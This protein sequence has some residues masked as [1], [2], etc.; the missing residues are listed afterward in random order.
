MSFQLMHIVLL[1]SAAHAGPWRSYEVYEPEISQHFVV[2]ASTHKLTYNH[3]STI[4]WFG[5]RWFCLWNANTIASEGKPGQLNYVSTSTDGITWSEPRAAFA[6]PEL[7]E[8][9]VPCPDGTQWQPNLIVVDGKLWAIWS[10]NS[11]DDYNGCYFSVLTD[12]DR[13]WSNTRLLFDYHHEPLIDGKRFR[14]FPTQNPCQLSPGRVLAPVTMI[15]PE[16]DDAPEG[17]NGWL[18]TEKRDSVIYTDDGG[19]SWHV[20]PGAVQENA[21]WA[22]WEPT[23]W[24]LADGKVMMFARNNDFRDAATGGPRPT[25]ALLW[26]ESGDGGETWTPHQHVPIETVVSRMHVTPA[27]GDRFMMVMNDWPAGKFVHDRYNHALFFTRGAGID[28]VAGLG[29]TGLEPFVHYPQM[30]TKD[31]SLLVSYSQGNLPRSIK[32]ARVSPLPK[33]DT[34]YLI[35]RSNLPP[36]PAPTREGDALVFN[37]KQYIEAREVTDFGDEA[38]SLGAWIRADGAGVLIDNRS[39]NPQAGFLWGL[40][41]KD[42]KLRPYFFIGSPERN[43]VSNLKV[44]RAQWSY[45]G[46]SVDHAGGAITFYAGEDAQTMAYAMPANKPTAL[47]PYIGHKRFEASQ[48]PSFTGLV[49]RLAV[50]ADVA[51]EADAHRRFADSRGAQASWTAPDMDLDPA[52]EAFN[53]DFVMPTAPVPSITHT[54]IDRRDVLR[55]AGE[56]SAGVE[57]EENTRDDMVEFSFSFLVE[58]GN[59]HVLCTIGDAN[60]PSRLVAKQGMVYLEAGDASEAVGSVRAGWTDVGLQTSGDMTR[61]TVRLGGSAA[62]IHHPAATWIYLGQGYRTDRIPPEN[63]CFIDIASVR[64]RV[65]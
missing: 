46:I 34:Y 23:L 61:A 62:V 57:L 22:Q 8:N 30:W 12:P 58:S 10:Q 16:A 17:I 56:A 35:P 28:F 36:P 51:V 14:L 13:K 7:S 18:R 48:V 38:F 25:E 32:V 45:V 42:G 19:E 59:E 64:S 55:I 54:T 52:S 65:E 11:R 37:G 27:G 21:T 6:D 2:N 40:A 50:R 53:T 49:R 29:I 47:T 1:A 39:T 15:G 3:D 20:S 41:F 60:Q 5:D 24:E 43:L 31:D 63:V 9:V 33:P 26:S 4:A 44:P